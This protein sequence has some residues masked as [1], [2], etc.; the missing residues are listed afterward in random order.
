MNGLAQRVTLA[1]RRRRRLARAGLAAAGR[2]GA[3]LALFHR[4]GTGRGGGHQFLRALTGELERTGA[5]VEH[6]RL[7]GATPACL[8]NGHNFD[9]DLLRAPLRVRRL[10]G[11]PPRIVHRVDGPLALYRGFDDGTDARINELN[12]ELADATIFQ[13]AASLDAHRELGLEFAQPTVI[14]NA[15]DPRIFHPGERKP[16]TGRKVRLISVSWSDNPNKGAA[17]YA[18]LEELLDWDQYEYTFVGQIQA[19]LRRITRVDPVDSHEVARLLRGHDVFITAS[20]NDPCSNAL[21]EAL[22]CGLPALYARSG[23]HPEIAGDAGFPFDTAEDVPGLLERL[24]GEYDERRSRIAVPSISKV[25]GRYRAVLG[26]DGA[27]GAAA[28]Q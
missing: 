27:H 4:F 3:D 9:P 8:V 2:G 17:T 11:R 12:R 20:L 24:A 10:R 7:S 6:E 16:L 22:S 21:V 13:S 15:A 26:L 23:G 25:A 1:V 18:A 19:D 14:M 5:R 28:Q